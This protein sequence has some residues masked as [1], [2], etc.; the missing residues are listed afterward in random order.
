MVSIAV[1]IPGSK[2]N[3][4]LPSLVFL[5]LVMVKVASAPLWYFRPLMVFTPLPKRFEGLALK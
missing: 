2:S 5:I 1:G 3:D 4:T